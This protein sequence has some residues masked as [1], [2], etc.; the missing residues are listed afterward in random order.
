MYQDKRYASISREGFLFP[1]R[2]IESFVRT[3]G[4]LT[5]MYLFV[6]VQQRKASRKEV[7]DEMAFPMR[8]FAESLQRSPAFAP[9]MLGA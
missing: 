3:Y 8:L 4:S 7:F 2:S 1:R 6:G 5:H 9:Q